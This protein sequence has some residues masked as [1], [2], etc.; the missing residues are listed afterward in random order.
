MTYDIGHDVH[1]TYDTCHTIAYH[2]PIGMIVAMR[3]IEQNQTMKPPDW[4]VVLQA[5]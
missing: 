4:C 3:K 1:M 2:H 5:T